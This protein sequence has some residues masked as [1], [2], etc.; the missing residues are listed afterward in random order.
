MLPEWMASRACQEKAVSEEKYD[1]DGP[2][3]YECGC[4]MR[5]TERGFYQCVNCKMNTEDDWLDAAYRLITKFGMTMEE[6]KDLTRRK[7]DGY[8]E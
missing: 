1:F 4:E 7:D 6:V 8:H 2:V 3:C 5:K